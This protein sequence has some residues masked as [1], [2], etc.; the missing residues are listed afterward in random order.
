MATRK[1]EIKIDPEVTQTP[2]IDLNVLEVRGRGKKWHLY[3]PDPQNIST[4]H[5]VLDRDGKVVRV[6]SSQ[7]ATNKMLEVHNTFESKQEA[8]DAAEFI[9]P[10]C[11]V[12]VVTTGDYTERAAKS[13]ATR[14]ANKE[15]QD[16]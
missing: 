7:V 8:I 11:T 14:R 3:Y 15:A 13:A 10:G 5:K 1:P 4:R 9:K 12:K 16:D 2:T 6:I